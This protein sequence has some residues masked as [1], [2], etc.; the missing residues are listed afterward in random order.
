M[1]SSWE[2]EYAKRAVIVAASR[3]DSVAYFN[4]V[5]HCLSADPVSKRAVPHNK[6]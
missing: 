4:A 1:M 5:I 3:I 6:F 2:L